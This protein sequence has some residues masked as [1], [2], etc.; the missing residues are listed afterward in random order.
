ME[1]LGVDP[2]GREVW[3]QWSQLRDANGACLPVVT[4]IDQ[5]RMDYQVIVP[6]PKLWGL[7]ATLK[8]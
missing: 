1:R 6:V 7:L 8:G 4:A 3:F 5:G 2:E